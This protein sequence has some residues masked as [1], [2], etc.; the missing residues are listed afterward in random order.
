MA[1]GR[2]CGRVVVLA[3]VL[4]CV[5]LHGELAESTEN[6]VGDSSGW[7][8]GVGG[9][10]KGKRFRAGDVL[11]FKYPAGAHT[12][13]AVDAAGYSTCSAPAGAK[14]YTSGN[15]RV[16]LARGTN[17]FICGIAGHCAAGMRIAV[18]AA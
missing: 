14:T 5:L 7:G 4:L 8:F 10:P 6:T 3:S 9:W 18:T 1:Q 13:V 12:V 17:F 2:D 16:T 11:V 15:D